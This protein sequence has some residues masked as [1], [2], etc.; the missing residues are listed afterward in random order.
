M[1]WRICVFGSLQLLPIKSN[2][3]G[4]NSNPIAL[5]LAKRKSLLSW[6]HSSSREALNW[7]DGENLRC[8][9]SKLLSNGGLHTTARDALCT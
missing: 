8:S 6:Y 3:I 1:V 7:V 5:A 4:R 9:T 2:R